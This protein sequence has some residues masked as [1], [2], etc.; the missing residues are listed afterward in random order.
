MHIF[1]V[2]AIEDEV[3]WLIKDE[4]SMASDSK[5]SNN[6]DTVRNKSLIRNSMSSTK[7]LFP[8]SKGGYYPFSLLGKESQNKGFRKGATI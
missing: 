6:S 8:S 5:D 1:F 2:W 3:E 7:E 4:E